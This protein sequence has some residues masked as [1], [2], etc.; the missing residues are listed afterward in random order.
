MI[1]QDFNIWPYFERDVIRVKKAER[2]VVNSVETSLYAVNKLLFG[3]GESTIEVPKR[4]VVGI[5][6][7]KNVWFSGKAYVFEILMRPVIEINWNEYNKVIKRLYDDKI[8]IYPEN[9]RFFVIDGEERSSNWFTHAYK[10]SPIG[11]SDFEGEELRNREQ[12]HKHL[13]SHEGYIIL[14]GKAKIRVGAELIEIRKDQMLVVEPDEIHR[15]ESIEISE[16]GL[17]RHICW[18]FPSYPYDP[19]KPIERVFVSGYIKE[20]EEHV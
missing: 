15:I 3:F 4:T 8:V 20:L 5:K 7:E 12:F 16:D 10:G 1:K 18:Q 9:S 2:G 13:R 17:Y 19:K 14:S 11:I 6:P